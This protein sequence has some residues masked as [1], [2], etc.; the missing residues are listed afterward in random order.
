[1]VGRCTLAAAAVSTAVP[2]LTLTLDANPLR[3]DCRMTWLLD[4]VDSVD[5]RVS[6]TCWTDPVT[7]TPGGIIAA[8]QQ[9]RES[10]GQL[11]ADKD[12]VY[13]LTTAASN[14][15]AAHRQL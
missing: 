11:A 15:T 10:C 1:M 5:L 2:R 13:C 6:G 12:S 14:S 7:P 9:T 8:L 3:C 4:V